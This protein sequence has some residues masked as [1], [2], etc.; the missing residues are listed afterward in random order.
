MTAA[1]PATRMMAS[2]GTH[3][4]GGPDQGVGG[5]VEAGRVG[6][7]PGEEHHGRHQPAEHH[8]H[9]AAFQR[10]GPVLAPHHPPPAEGEGPPCTAPPG[11]PGLGF[12]DGGGHRS[13]EQPVG[14]EAEAAHAGHQQAGGEASGRRRGAGTA[15]SIARSPW[16]RPAGA[17]G[18][19]RPPSTGMAM[20]RR[21][22][23]PLVGPPR[24][25]AGPA[26]PLT[27]HL[28]QLAAPRSTTPPPPPRARRGRR[29][30]PGGHAWIGQRGWAAPSKQIRQPSRIPR[31]A[32][33][34][35]PSTV[36]RPAEPEPVRPGRQRQAGEG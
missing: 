3:R 11:R 13:V 15:G 22:W 27:L 21:A 2:A 23:K 34:G 10:V 1:R 24:S 33:R 29:A 17:S 7:Q 36:T 14:P 31:T 26:D 35:S 9:S 25:F 16:R 5:R 32:P 20:P 8:A 28:T 6:G 4:E 19:G 12:R 18:R 30:A